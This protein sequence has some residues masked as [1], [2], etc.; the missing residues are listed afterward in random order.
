MTLKHYLVASHYIFISKKAGIITSWEV[1]P[2]N[3]PMSLQKVKNAQTH[4][5]QCYVVVSYHISILKRLA[6]IMIYGIYAENCH[7]WPFQSHEHITKVKGQAN[8][9]YITL[10][11]SRILN[12]NTAQLYVVKSHTAK[13]KACW[14][15][16]WYID[17]FKV[18]G[19]TWWAATTHLYTLHRYLDIHVQG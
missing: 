1:A 14:T 16:I 8:T 4:T 10:C 13:I 17:L 3:F 11:W 15:S 2:I 7:W 5:S 9:K 6:L 19:N 12:C 18:L